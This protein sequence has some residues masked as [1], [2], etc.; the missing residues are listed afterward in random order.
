MAQRSLPRAALLVAVLACWSAPARAADSDTAR[1]EELIRQANALRQKGQDPAALPLVREAYDVARSPRTAAQLGLVELALGY[2]VSSDDHL[3]EALTPAHH[4]WIDRN[5]KV[6][7]ESQANARAHVGTLVIE[8]QPA[9]AEVRVNFVRAGNLPQLAPIR[10][11]EG[12]VTIE[13]TAADHVEQK[14]TIMIR[15]ATTERV[16]FDLVP[17]K[18]EA[19][20]EAPPR[21][22]R[23]EPRSPPPPP[24]PAEKPAW[25]PVLPWALAGGAA[26]A[27]GVG[28]WQHVGWRHAQS[29]FDRVD[30]CGA[31]FPD[32][33]AD[34]RC[35][36]LYDTLAG[37]RTRA[38]V[39]YGVAGALGVGA[40][41]TF[42][43]NASEDSKEVAFGPGPTPLGLSFGGRF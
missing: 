39:S 6:L 26:V 37:R 17:V 42:I 15:G 40:A 2:W 21:P 1:A 38:Y 9:G 7:E 8:G 22:V 12:T 20:A 10:V 23:P 43:L 30:G 11:G 5:R 16:R 36:G 32:H 18:R 33:G 4:P 28:V 14:R 24:P 13:V 41:I 27:A 34:P 25:R 35:S 19:K 31:D 29:D 3:T